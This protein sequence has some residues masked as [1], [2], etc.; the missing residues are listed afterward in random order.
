MNWIKIDTID[1]YIEFIF[2]FKQY[3]NASIDN[4]V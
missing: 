3:K 2:R 1:D 4:F